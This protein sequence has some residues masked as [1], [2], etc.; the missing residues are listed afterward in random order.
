MKFHENPEFLDGIHGSSELSGELHAYVA[1]D[2][3]PM[4][5]GKILRCQRSDLG[6]GVLGDVHQTC[7]QCW[8]MLD[9]QEC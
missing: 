7:S 1:C 9:T 4:A 5:W 2:H 8:M 3:L 6:G